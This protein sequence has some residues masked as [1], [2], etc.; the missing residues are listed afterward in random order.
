MSEA[1]AIE[2]VVGGQEDGTYLCKLINHNNI[3]IG[4]Q[5][6]EWVTVNEPDVSE[7]KGSSLL[8][9]NTGNIDELKKLLPKITTPMLSPAMLNRLKISD[10]N[11]LA[12]AVLYF[13][14]NSEL[15][16]DVT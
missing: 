6:L 8:Q 15:S 11:R 10:M 2:R 12:G 3:M 14:Y 16:V 4:E 9:I 13:L 7:T 1:E 5:R